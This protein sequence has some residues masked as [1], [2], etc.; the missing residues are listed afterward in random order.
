MQGKDFQF[1]LVDELGRCY[2]IENAIVKLSATPRAL[3]F[4]PDGWQK[5]QISW[6][7]NN[8]YFG[9][10]RNFTIPLSFV[11]DGAYIIRH[12]HYT[13]NIE[14]KLYLV[15]HRKK[16]NI[17]WGVN[18]YAFIYKF[19][20]KGEIDLS[21]F[22]QKTINDGYKV[23][24]SIMEGGASKLLKSK[25]GTTYEIPCNENVSDAIKV[26]LDGIELREKLN[27]SIA[28]IDIQENRFTIPFP[29]LNSEGDSVG[30]YKTSQNFESIANSAAAVNTYVQTSNNYPFL[31]VKPITLQISGKL[32]IGNP[33]GGNPFQADVFFMTSLLNRYDLIRNYT[34]NPGASMLQPYSLTIT[35]AA[36]EKLFFLGRKNNT[37]TGTDTTIQFSD[38]SFS[39]RFSTRGDVSV[40]YALHGINLFKKLVDKIGEGAYQATSNLLTNKKNIA[41][42]SGNNLR[43]FT[44]AAIKTTLSDF[45]AY[46]NCQYNTGLNTS[47]T[48]F[49]IEAK[50]KYFDATN[51]IDLGEVKDLEISVGKEWMY[52]NLKIGYPSQTYETVNGKQEFNTSFQFQ[53]PINRIT[54]ELNL[55]CPYRADGYG[56][57]AIRTA[58]KAKETTDN[59]SDN[60]TFIIE[61]Q[62]TPDTDGVYNVKH[63][64]FISV[65]GLYSYNT[66]YNIGLSPTRLLYKSGSFIHSGL[67]GFDASK[68]TFQT[69][70]KNT[71]LK[72][73]D[74]NGTIEEKADKLISSLA[75]PLFQPILFDF[76]TKVMINIPELLEISPNP[77]FKF[78]YKQQMY[79]G[80]LLKG[81]FEPSGL[82][83]QAF[84]LLS[85][86]DNNLNHLING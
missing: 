41:V 65:T 51:P 22:K 33:A 63:P 47:D 66:A 43:G 11:E 29:Y 4:S 58:T 62:D 54:K 46:T 44:D 36:N 83:P 7:R 78:I 37:Y 15:V 34:L 80:F 27:Y 64:T 59:Q 70:D 55:I 74:A 61:I 3:E 71:D 13:S 69:G 68:I 8:K 75:L 28:G 9:V 17:D 16:L 35:L 12:V 20:Y 39:F 81:S 50:T 85:S 5:L 42:L 53:F 18:E 32:G 49:E 56:I 84:T 2:Y 30:I 25:E 67:L 45:F 23:Q 82:E 21:T 79:K 52:N 86:P 10:T 19:L 48:G 72:T 31:S 1:F 73:V 38:T 77:C 40:V 76:T 57:E 60:D 26:R 24:V 6:E 14:N